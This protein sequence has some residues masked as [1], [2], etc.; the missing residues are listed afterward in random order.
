MNQEESSP[1]AEREKKRERAAQERKYTLENMYAVKFYLMT[2]RFTTATW[3]ENR[4][5]LENTPFKSGYCSPI[6]VSEKI[7]LDFNLGVIEM[8]N[9]SDR[10]I[11]IGLVKNKLFPK[12]HIYEHG[13]YNRHSY[14][15][16]RRIDRNEMNKEEE[17]LMEVLEKYCFKG[18]G[19][20]KR[21]QGLSAFPVRYLYD[22]YIEGIDIIK[23]I[24][25][26][27]NRRSSKNDVSK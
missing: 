10:I 16:K 1:I 23:V 22:S 5:Y 26:M 6:P 21:G 4:K 12:M 11:G 2:S 7:P 25:N 20:L 14:L 19:H 24:R 18:K 13:N 27:F 3:T 15:G 17:K 9:E 8:D